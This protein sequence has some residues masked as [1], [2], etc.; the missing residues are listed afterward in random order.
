MP[1]EPLLNRK[2]AAEW[3]ATRGLRHVT[4]THLRDLADRGKGPE[5]SRMG[6]HAY[7]APSALSAWLSTALKPV[8][9]TRAPAAPQPR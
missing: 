5:Y 2:E 9:R 8:T 4:V 6:R 3:F 7:Y 1:D